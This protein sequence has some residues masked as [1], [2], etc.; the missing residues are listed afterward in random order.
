[1]T[2]MA[3]LL[4]Q[5]SPFRETCTWTWHAMAALSHR[6]ET[7]GGPRRRKRRC[8]VSVGVGVRRPVVGCE[9]FCC[10]PDLQYL[11]DA[12]VSLPGRAQ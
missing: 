5:G 7:W 10:G 4:D 11:L 9:I 6:R 8:H 3:D 2:L 1:M 12:K